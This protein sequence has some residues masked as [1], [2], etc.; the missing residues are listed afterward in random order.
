MDAPPTRYART[1]D[2][3]S[4]AY[5]DVGAGLPFIFMPAASSHVQLNWSPAHRLAKWLPGLSERFRLICYDGRGQGMSDR[6]VGPVYS[7]SALIT[8]LEAVVDRLQLG[9]FVL[10]GSHASGHAAVSYAAA[11]LERVHSLVL[12]PT[13]ISGRQ[14]SVINNVDLARKN[15]EFF[16]YFFNQH[17]PTPDLRTENVEILRKSVNQDDWLR[18]ASTWRDSDVGALLPNVVTPT[19]ILHP[20]DYLNIP[21]ASS[22]QVAAMIPKSRLSLIEGATT[23]GDAASGLQALDEFFGELVS[24]A[25]TAGRTIAGVLSDRELEVLRLLAAGR[26][27]QQIADELVISV[28]TVNRHVSNVYAKTGVANRAEAATYAARHGIA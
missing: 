5:S 18:M 24:N 4:I 19:L 23:F 20:R 15:W 7:M 9:Q 26:S 10:M 2:G 22:S 25:G 21:I 17:T 8:D 14:W 12:T 13:S 6:G 11:H 28:N 16:L 27:N 3:Y 1:S